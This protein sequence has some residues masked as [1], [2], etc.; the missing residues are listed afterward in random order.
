MTAYNDPS[1]TCTYCTQTG[2]I[3]NIRVCHL[4]YRDYYTCIAFDYGSFSGH[5]YRYT[6]MSEMAFGALLFSTNLMNTPPEESI[7]P[8]IGIL[9]VY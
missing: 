9:F 7:K 1:T 4:V 2:T 8:F 3:L 5:L 6:C